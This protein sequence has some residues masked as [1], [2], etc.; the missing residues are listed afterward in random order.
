MKYLSRLILRILGWKVILEIPADLKKYVVAVA[1]HT[2]WKDFFLGLV[3]RS[4]IGRKIY[5]LGKKEL[6]DSP[7]G[8]FFWWT[9][10]RPVDRKQKTG[11]VDQVVALFNGSEEFAIG[12]APEGTRK[13]GK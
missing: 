4:S 12:I 9:G 10:G 11:L 2:S 13:K 3:V 8:F 5:Y 7:F 1:P 6:F